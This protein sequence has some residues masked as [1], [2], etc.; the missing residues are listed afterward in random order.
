[1]KLRHASVNLDG[2]LHVTLVDDDGN[3]ELHEFGTGH[4]DDPEEVKRAKAMLALPRE[5]WHGILNPKR[6]AK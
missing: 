1:M 2:V 5:G 4:L 3:Q 6:N